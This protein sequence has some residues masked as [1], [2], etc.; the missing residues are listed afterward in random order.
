MRVRPQPSSELDDESARVGEPVIL[1]VTHS[2]DVTADFMC[3]RL[4]RDDVHFV[5]IDSDR[6]Q[7]NVAVSL[8]HG[9][10]Q[11]RIEHG[12]IS[13]DEVACIWLRRPKPIDVQADDPAEGA[14]TSLEW[15]SAVEAFLG[16]ID[17][18]RW[19]NHPSNNAAAS[20]KLEQLIRAKRF[21]L[22]VPQ[23]LVTQDPTEARAFFEDHAG[24][25][26]VKPISHG[27]LERQTP[28]DDTLIYTCRVTAESLADISLV[29][30]CPT[31]FQAEIDKAFDVRVVSV[32][33]RV[34][35]VRLS[36]RAD[37]ERQI[38]DV[39]RDNMQG[40][41][42][43][44]VDVPHRTQTALL[45]LLTSYRLRFAAVDFAVDA[46]GEWTFFEVNANGQWAWLDQVGVTDL[47]GDLEWAM[48]RTLPE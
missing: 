2:T 44:V 26:I 5:R 17:P 21:G 4:A 42:Y 19:I 15:G 31:L 9:K 29:S 40:V 48:T 46:K 7:G 3:A 43:A 28:A 18:R 33:G 12:G 10:F 16:C 38:L 11:L 47:A 41:E 1:V 20:R 14:H 35:A 45:S 13:P 22:N 24:A 39:R 8:R 37:G 27:Y 34:R 30:R 23:T 25:I 36:R 32:D 6:V